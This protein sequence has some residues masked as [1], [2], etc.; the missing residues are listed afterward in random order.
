MSI[1]SDVQV[2]DLYQRFPVSKVIR[3]SCNV[4][5]E[6]YTV[7]FIPKYGFIVTFFLS[8]AQ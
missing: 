8:G 2:L 6:H 4:M 3:H 5:N 7:Y 1:N